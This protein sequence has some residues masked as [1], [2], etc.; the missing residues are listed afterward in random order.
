MNSSPSN[1]AN[2]D[3]IQKVLKVAEASSL[4]SSKQQLHWKEL[5]FGLRM[6]QRQVPSCYMTVVLA[7]AVLILAISL[8]SAMNSSSFKQMMVFMVVRSGDLMRQAMERIC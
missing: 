2:D 1:K 6:E 8:G 3:L 5:N 4:F 7:N